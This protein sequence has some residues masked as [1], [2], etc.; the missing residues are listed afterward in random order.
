MDC[1][2]LH[3]PLLLGWQ[4]G[5]ALGHLRTAAG[6][7]R[8]LVYDGAL[9]KNSLR[10]QPHFLGD[11]EMGRRT[12]GI[13]HRVTRG[14][15]KIEWLEPRCVLNAA[16]LAILQNGPPRPDVAHGGLQDRPPVP[17][18]VSGKPIADANDASGGQPSKPSK[19]EHGPKAP[20]P[21]PVAS[22]PGPLAGP[23]D[24]DLGATADSSADS[25]LAIDSVIASAVVG[26]PAQAVPGADI[27]SPPQAQVIVQID[28]DVASQPSPPPT[29]TDSLVSVAVSAHPPAAADAAVT[30]SP[31]DLANSRSVEAAATP[32]V[33]LIFN[34]LLAEG[35]TASGAS[36][37]AQ[38]SLGTAASGI[39]ARA[40]TAE[41]LATQSLLPSTPGPNSFLA[42][43]AP[44]GGGGIVSLVAPEASPHA[45][46]STGGT[47]SAA[48]PATDS[49]SD[50]TSDG[51]VL[52][53][54]ETASGIGRRIA[55]AGLPV[56]L[57]AVDHAIETVM[58]EIGQ[59]G[60]DFTR[61]WD[62]RH[63]EP[64]AIA[65]GAVA[66]GAAATYYMRRRG[67]RKLDEIEEEA[68]T[69]WLFARLQPVPN[70]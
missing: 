38:Q 23:T 25:Q 1:R 27:D 31:D 40:P 16:P 19:P 7:Y 59:L 9:S 46:E 57:S 26:V 20:P 3:E 14:F 61:W 4:Q 36:A 52:S 48:A 70:E 39:A 55:M 18:H 2:H 64:A 33:P 53:T 37:Q 43:A 69:S 63:F 56:N 24:P 21:P 6:F 68:S 35:Q 47:K 41:V 66:L 12:R 50:P 11:V 34:S 13:R 22:A 54:G 30:I 15:R 29:S 65:A 42:V 28:I 32:N 44:T 5:M 49:A 45:S 67:S 58:G 62:G 51:E 8:R 17:V 60:G 10:S